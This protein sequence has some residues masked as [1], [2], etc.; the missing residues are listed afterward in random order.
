[1]II[2][3]AESSK[4]PLIAVGD[5]NST[6]S[7]FPNSKRSARG[8]NAMDVLIESRQFDL[9]AQAQNEMTYPSPLPTRVIDWILNPIGWSFD[10]YHV[11]SSQLSDHRPVVADLQLP[12]DS[13]E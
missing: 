10:D 4:I 9:N 6:P 12:I 13:R 8:Q 3:A 11:I 7:S 2:E 5:F 1:M